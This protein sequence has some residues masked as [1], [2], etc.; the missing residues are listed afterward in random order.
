MN[1]GKMCVSTWSGVAISCQ[2]RLHACEL[3]WSDVGTN[4]QERLHALQIWFGLAEIQRNVRILHLHKDMTH[5]KMNIGTATTSEI[6]TNDQERICDGVSAKCYST[7]A[8]VETMCR[9]RRDA[10]TGVLISLQNGT[11]C[12]SNITINGNMTAQIHANFC[13]VKIREIRLQN[14]TPPCNK[15]KPNKNDDLIKDNQEHQKEP[16]Q[17]RR[18]PAG[19]MNKMDLLL[20]VAAGMNRDPTPHESMR[21]MELLAISIA[22]LAHSCWKSH[23]RM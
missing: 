20:Q 5:I 3:T 1:S 14:E 23:H 13:Q 18:P 17:P 21:V 8:Q 9:A 4:C 11:W 15:R 10:N 7:R 2:E 22:Q 16:P 6:P 12:Q 19:S